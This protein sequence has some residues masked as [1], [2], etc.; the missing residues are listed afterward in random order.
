MT[1]PH[2][3]VPYQGPKFAKD[4]RRARAHIES[5]NLN[6]ICNGLRDDESVKAIGEALS[7]DG[8]VS[9]YTCWMKTHHP[10]LDI[11]YDHSAM[12][13]ARLYWLDVMIEENEAC[14]T[15]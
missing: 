3:K 11:H 5:R 6:Y 8:S 12:R 9:S 7:D 4:L 15:T 2:P 1:Y 13:L 14:T 10:E